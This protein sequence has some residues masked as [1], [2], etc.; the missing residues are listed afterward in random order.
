MDGTA[1]QTP[2][3]DVGTAEVIDRFY[4]ALTRGDVA[5][6]RACVTADLTVWHSFDR[7]A[8]GLEEAVAGWEDM[9]AGF[10]ERSFVD[11]RRSPVPGGWVQRQ[12]MMGR[13]AS[14]TQVAWPVCLF[15]TLRDRLI[16]RID[17]YIDRAG[18]Y[19]PA[20]DT[21]ATPGLPPSR[22][23]GVL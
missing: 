6:A 23:D 20:G 16:S 7:I 8:I 3:P 12:Q 13:T 22:L 4:E 11:V 17:E 14:G 15:V 10:P 5:G 18:R 2:L 9:V 21:T 1:A 19:E